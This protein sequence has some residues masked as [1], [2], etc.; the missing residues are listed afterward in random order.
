LV[1]AK[2]AAGYKIHLVDIAARFK[3]VSN[4]AAVLMDDDLHP[5]DA[6]YA[7]MAKV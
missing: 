6:G 4:W 1:K 2:A 3:A 7:V 5:N